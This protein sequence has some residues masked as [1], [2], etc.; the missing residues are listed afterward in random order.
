MRADVT[1]EDVLVYEAT[2]D[3]DGKPLEAFSLAHDYSEP[4]LDVKIGLRELE[5]TLLERKWNL[6]L[7]IISELQQDLL[8]AA[9]LIARKN[10]GGF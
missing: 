4:L 7:A 3:E 2:H 5:D 8:H 10:E 6:A 1:L 9:M